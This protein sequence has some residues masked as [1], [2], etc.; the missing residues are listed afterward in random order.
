MLS[1][2]NAFRERF[3]CMRAPHEADQGAFVLRVDFIR[4]TVDLS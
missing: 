4:E 1:D 3:R 2:A